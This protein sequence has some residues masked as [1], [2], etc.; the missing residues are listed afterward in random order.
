MEKKCNENIRK[1]GGPVK[2]WY[3]LLYKGVERWDKIKADI[4]EELKE[5]EKKRQK[6]TFQFE[7]IWFRPLARYCSAG[8]VTTQLVARQVGQTHMTSQLVGAVSIVLQG[9]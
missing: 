7:I 8:G 4:S 9:Y 2:F 1:K 3:T 6:W 5:E